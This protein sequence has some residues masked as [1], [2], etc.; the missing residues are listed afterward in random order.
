VVKATS[1]NSS[2]LFGVVS[3]SPGVLLS[4]ISDSNG[5]T[6][7]VN[8]KPIALSGRIPTNVST[9]NGPISIGDYLTISSTPGVAMKATAAGPV[10]GRALEDYSGSGVGS[11][12]VLAEAGYYAGPSIAQQLQQSS[13]DSLTATGQVTAQDLQVNN[14]AT[15]SNLLATTGNIQNLTS[16]SSSTSA[17]TVGGSASVGSLVSTGLVTTQDL[18][19]NGAATVS[20]LAVSGSAS[21]QQDLTV[22]GTTTTGTLAVVGNAS[23]GGNLTVTGALAA[24]SLNV[25]GDLT[26]NGHVVTGNA[27]GATTASVNAAA[28]SA[29]SPSC[30]VSGNDTGGQIT[31]I[32][33]TSGWTP[34]V[35]CTITFAQS[36]S[37]TPHPVI[38]S[39]NSTT[40]TAVEPY[41]DVPGAAPFTTF[42]INF[43]AADTAQH[44]YKFNYFNAQ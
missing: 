16:G 30:S 41:V 6:N 14:T 4:G 29:G 20:S 44:T 3:T 25:A 15:V 17:L 37:S 35:Q 36:Y 10:I 40:I 18:Q 19:V 33:G 34:G 42:T 27:S 12:E 22:V 32:T 38:T 39:A 2:E 28:G 21:I 24:G 11:I 1:A 43:I 26:V 31:L 7:L 9:E 23:V 8:P 13:I 5:S